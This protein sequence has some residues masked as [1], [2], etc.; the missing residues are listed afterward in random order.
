MRGFI[1]IKGAVCLAG[2]SWLAGAGNVLAQI[3]VTNNPT[4]DAFV[5]SVQPTQNYGVAGALS[6]SGSIA[7]NTLGAQG[8][9]LDS[10]L[11]FNV[12]NAV[13]SFNSAF[14]VGQWAIS[15]VTLGVTAQPPNN[16]DFNFGAGPFAVNWLGNNSWLEGTGTPGSPT[17]NGITYAQEPSLLNSNV[18]ESL[19]TFTYGGATSGRMNLSLGLPSGFISEISTGSLVSLYMTETPNSTVGFTFPS[20]NFGT[21]SA[22][23]GLILTAVAIPEPATVVLLGLSGAALA[24]VGRRRR[25]SRHAAAD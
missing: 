10:F 8:G 13:A 3:T 24:A 9:L 19:G 23:P 25:K 2:C 5:R 14:G 20:E 4:Q 7:T 1:I 12:T 16:T 11:Q 22:R 18:D 17:T 15:S 6:V 21:A